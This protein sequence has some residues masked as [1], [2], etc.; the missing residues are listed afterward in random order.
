M[1][2]FYFT[3]ATFLILFGFFSCSDTTNQV[4]EENII[5]GVLVDEQDI[6]VPNAVI[7]IIRVSQGKTNILVNEEIVASDT[8]DDDG[9]FEF[10]N[11]PTPLGNLKIK[12]YHR[13][14]K[15]FEDNILT[16][17]EKQP[18]NKLRF[19]LQHNDDCCGKIIIRTIGHD[20]NA[21]KEVEVRLNR[22]SEKVKKSYT[23]NDGVVVFERVCAGN[24]WVRIAKQGYQVIE[25]EFSLSNC[26]TLE[27]TFVL[28][29]KEQDTCCKGII[30]VEVKNQNNEFLNGSIVKLRKN[31]ALLT[32]LTI[33]E[34]SPVFFRELCPGTYSLLILKDGYKAVERNVSIECNDSTFISIQMEEDTCCNSVLRVFIKN[35]EGQPLN[36]AKVAIWKSGT[37]LGFY[38]TNDS[39]LVI[40]RNLCKGV[41]EFSVQKEG[42]KSIEFSVEI[43]CNEEKEV[44]KQLQASEKDTCCNG[45]IKI[46]VKN[47]EEQP[48]SQAIVSIWKDGKKLSYNS[49]NS[50]GY[51]IFQKLCAGKYSFDIKREGYKPIEFF[52]ELGCNEEK[53][54]TKFLQ[55]MES[56]SCCYGVLIIR[57]KDKTNETAING[58]G[59][60][61]WKGGQ[62]VKQG[63][64]S[65]GVAVFKNI[66]P[67]EYGV[68]ILKDTYKTLEF[69]LKFECNDTIEITKLLES[70]IKDTCCKGKVILYI[71]DSTNN[72]PIKGV[73]V[74][75]WKGSQK[76][77][78][79][80]SNENGKVVFENLCEG[81]YQISMIK[82]GYRGLE[83]NFELGCNETKEFVKYLVPKTDSCCTA[84]LKL[85]VLDDSTGSAI[86]GANVSVR[87]NGN[88]VL[89][90]ST[91]VE[92]WVVFE[93]LCAPKTY[94]VRISAEGYNV[95]EINFTFQDC[96][97]IQET[98]R[99]KR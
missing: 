82:S 22:G 45:F 85:K 29:R 20:S 68:S 96:N 91:N 88:V 52:V 2:K 77:S 7:Y 25:R 59:V 37:K 47:N 38:L 72:N 13:D 65:E 98:I 21:L 46:F 6:P 62:V 64:T 89:E 57:V 31:G 69:S 41:Y 95:K 73:E 87:L 76:I 74:K 17:L 40:L 63:T 70:E 66:C 1:K 23:N 39:G 67:G 49:T 42:F 90:R 80:A 14:F 4:S 81:N 9:N 97:T 56:D 44:T 86:S 12:I 83:F 94:S 50:D 79:Q 58:A 75:L 3:L 53:E 15:I 54:I 92:G 35:S 34:N 33:K 27:Y 11:L 71:K 36:Q 19:R 51:V 8:T 43:G 30:G 48:L 32:T 5:K 28:S 60:K 18:R 93:D 84:R 61:I 99:L 78:A 24:Y 55:R 16:L 10:S 26:D